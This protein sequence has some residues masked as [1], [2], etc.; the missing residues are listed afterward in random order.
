MRRYAHYSFAIS[1]LWL[2]FV[3]ALSF[4]EAPLKFKAPGVELAEALS[5]GRLVFDSLNRFEWV[6]AGFSWLLMLK[7]KVVRVPGV[8]WVL[9]V[10]TAILV[11]Q[12]WGLLPVLDERT[13]RVTAGEDVPASWHH[14]AYIMVEVVKALSLAVLASLQV[15]GFA[16]AVISE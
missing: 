8:L 5:I 16:R 11:F 12:T 15:Q 10:I 9:G 1:F 2:G 3:C 7:L 13:L 4:L 14:Q 6:C